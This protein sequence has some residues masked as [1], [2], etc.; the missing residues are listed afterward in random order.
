MRAK[1]HGIAVAKLPHSQRIVI[2]DVYL[3][4]GMMHRHEQLLT[5]IAAGGQQSGH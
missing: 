2:N 3:C 5:V 4:V 1:D